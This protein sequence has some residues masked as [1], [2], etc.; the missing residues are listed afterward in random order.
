MLN[1]TADGEQTT[2][3]LVANKE[4]S[5]RCV[6]PTALNAPPVSRRHARRATVRRHRIEPAKE[7]AAKCFRFNNKQYCE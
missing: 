7:V 5:E 6:A 1:C 2:W 3:K 4:L